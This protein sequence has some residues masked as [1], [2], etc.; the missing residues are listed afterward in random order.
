ML[1]A[2]ILSSSLCHTLG[3]SEFI[4]NTYTPN[5]ET[6]F[7]QAS[8]LDISDLPLLLPKTNM[9][10]VP[11]YAKMGLLAAAKTLQDAGFAIPSGT[12]EQST[13]KAKNMALVIGTAFS[14]S[15]M[16][17]DFMD[18]ILDN[19]P[20]LSSPTAFSH[21]VNNMGAGLISLI[22]D[23]QGGCQTIT[24]FDQSF[25]GAIQSA[26]LLLASGKNDYVLVGAVDELDKRFTYTCKEKLQSTPYPLTE[27][28]VF[29]LLGKEEKG[30]KEEKEENKPAISI[31][32]QEENQFIHS[33]ENEERQIFLSGHAKDCD[34]IANN[35]C[36]IVNN[37]SFYGTTPLAQA[38]DTFLAI[39]SNHVSNNSICACKQENSHTLALL[40][41]NK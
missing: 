27:G 22:L 23:I 6:D 34:I 29:F 21:A 39:H 33:L 9:R 7:K 24:Q 36:K 15:Q 2:S 41:I 1:R 20:E 19:S 28:A 5:K 14:S 26:L 17:I 25:A 35:N 10:R 38:L 8:E 37:S 31:S 3:D 18:S 32:W 11:R 12:Q 4:L 30:E 16:N 13:Q 40:E